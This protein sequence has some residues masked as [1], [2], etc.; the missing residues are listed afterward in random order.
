MSTCPI[1]NASQESV[2]TEGLWNV[3]RQTKLVL[4]IKRTVDVRLVDDQEM[5]DLNGRFR[6]VAESTDVL[7]FPSGLDDPLPLGDIAICVP[8]AIR[9]AQLRE[10]GLNNELAALLIHG[11]LHLVGYDDIEDKDRRDMQ[12][13]MNEVGSKLGIP[14]DAEWTSVLHQ[15]ETSVAVEHSFLGHQ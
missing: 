9:Q 4:H 14:I 13:K 5:T 11:C 8:Y 15:V 3:L 10:V 7:T 2:D 6:N 1:E 12:S